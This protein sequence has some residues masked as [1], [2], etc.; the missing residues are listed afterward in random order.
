MKSMIEDLPADELTFILGYEPSKDQIL[1]MIEYSRTTKQPLGQIAQD[2]SLPPMFTDWDHSGY[3][4]TKDAGRIKVADY[5]KLHPW[6]RLI[7]L[8]T[9]KED[10]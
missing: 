1:E 9:Q 8:T 7:I 5:Q 10:N 3:I 6:L 2:R 4:D